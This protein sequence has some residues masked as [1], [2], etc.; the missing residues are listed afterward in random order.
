MKSLFFYTGH[1]QLKE[2]AY[3]IAFLKSQSLPECDFV[4][5]CNNKN[6]NPL[7]FKHNVDLIGGKFIWTNKNSGK[8]FGP[9]E[10]ISDCYSLFNQYKYVIHLHPDVFIHDIK[11]IMA[12]L[13]E[14]FD[15]CVQPVNKD[16]YCFD[17]FIFRPGTIL[18]GCD[19][20][21]QTQ[22]KVNKNNNDVEFIPE[23]F[24]YEHIN[25]LP[26]PKIKY[27]DR[28]DNPTFGYNGIDKM[29]LWHEHDLEKVEKYLIEHNIPYDNTIQIKQEVD[30][31]VD[32]FRHFTA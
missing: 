20:P 2:I 5:H 29:G 21:P 9:I 17:F 22:T 32:C 28:Y 26:L 7:D 14:E 12:L 25:S 30:R 24:L 11:P 4:F 16:Q 6:I 3:S 10:A 18:K 31:D 13:N 15:V 8:A 23:S 1:R 19:T 27:M